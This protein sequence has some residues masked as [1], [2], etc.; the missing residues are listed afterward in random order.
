M[1]ELEKMAEEMTQEA[2]DNLESILAEVKSPTT[3][4]ADDDGWWTLVSGTLVVTSIPPYCS[5]SIMSGDRV[6][7]DTNPTER[8]IPLLHPIA[9]TRGT[10]FKFEPWKEGQG[11]G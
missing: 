10:K 5:L 6:M 9:I 4:E 8:S 3:I 2:L 11:E 7:G 1:G